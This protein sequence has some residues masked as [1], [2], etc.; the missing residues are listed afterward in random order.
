[1]VV[2][3]IDYQQNNPTKNEDNHNFKL[4]LNSHLFF[5][6][7]EKPESNEKLLCRDFSIS[8]HCFNNS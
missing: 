3:K 7:F 2:L 1:M 5:F 8:Y 4:R 6:E